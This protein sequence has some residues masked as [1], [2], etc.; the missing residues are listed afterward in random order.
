MTAIR[1]KNLIKFLETLDS[2][3][4]VANGFGSPHS[5]RGDY[6]NLAFSPEKETTVGEMLSYAKSANGKT[7]TGWTGGDYLMNLDTPVYIGREGYWGE[8][9]TTFAFRYWKDSAHLP[10]GLLAYGEKQKPGQR[11]KSK[12][13]PKF[14]PQ[15]LRMKRAVEFLKGYFSDYSKQRYYLDYTDDTLIEDTLYALGV[16]LDPEKYRFGPGYRKFLVW[17][18]GYL[19]EPKGG[20]RT[21]VPKTEGDAHGV[22]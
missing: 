20:E 11:K 22:L 16:A 8:P 13:A 19:K 10:P 5:D 18:R 21:L 17:L 15:Q 12:K 9:I 2:R 4:I 1:L 3:A 14:S 7:F 6:A